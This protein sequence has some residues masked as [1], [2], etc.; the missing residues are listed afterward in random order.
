MLLQKQADKLD[1]IITN[2]TT[3]P[4]NYSG[5]LKEMGLIET[6][7][8]FIKQV[9]SNILY[10]TYPPSPHLSNRL[11]SFNRSNKYNLS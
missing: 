5:V 9:T 7:R 4:I 6:M 11:S 2:N 3:P 1:G 10:S 8:T